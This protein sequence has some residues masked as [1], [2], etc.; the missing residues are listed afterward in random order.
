MK[1]TESAARRR[2]QA[3]SDCAE[4]T[5]AAL[6]DTRFDP[7]RWFLPNDDLLGFVRV[8]AGRFLMGSDDLTDDEKPMHEVELPPFWIARFPTT[9]AQ[10]RAFS[11]QSG[12]KEFDPDAL[13]SP[14][15]H[16]VVYVNWGDALEYCDWL[17]G[18]LVELAKAREREDPLWQ[19]LANGNLRATLPS[20][21]EWEKAARG[22]DGRVYP[23]GDEFDSEKANV[24]ETGIG[25]TSAV[26]SFPLGASPYGALDMV[27]NVWEW[28]R[29]IF[30]EW[31]G[32]RDGVVKKNTYPYIPNDGREDLE[33]STDFLRVIRGGSFAHERVDAPCAYRGWDCVDFRCDFI[34]FRVV[35]SPREAP[36]ERPK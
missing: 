27:G 30:G 23:W 21:A 5:P 24:D 17:N 4:G 18:E 19:G 33:R 10:F 13:R 34:G 2:A 15:D 35:V 12:Y 8:P 6:G 36:S 14:D 32:E 3:D 16:P 7:S 31:D 9:V 26:G 22:T 11:E 28:T 29:S 20:E 1:T 25:T